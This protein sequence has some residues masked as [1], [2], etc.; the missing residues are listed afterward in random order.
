M[1]H[2][3]LVIQSYDYTNMFDSISLD[4]TISDLYD[5]GVEDDMLVLLDA[6]NRNM[7]IT[8]STCYGYT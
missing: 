4:I 5:S 8:V 1:K 7:K 2:A 3:Q 6:V